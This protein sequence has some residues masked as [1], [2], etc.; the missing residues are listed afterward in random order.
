MSP[1][2][3]PRRK[4][5]SNQSTPISQT[6]ATRSRASI[7]AGFSNLFRRATGRRSPIVTDEPPAT[8]DTSKRGVIPRLLPRKAS[9]AGGNKRIVTDPVTHLRGTSSASSTCLHSPSQTP[10]RNAMPSINIPSSV[11]EIFDDENIHTS[12]DISAAI[13]ATEQE[14][15]RLLHDFNQLETTMAYRVHLQTARRLPPTIPPPSPDRKSHRR[16]PAPLDLSDGASVDSR[17]SD[18]TSLSQSKSVSSLRSKLY[19]PS[20]LSPRFFP[21]IHSTHS[22]SSF[23]SQVPSQGRAVSASASRS[24]LVDH[25]EG[26]AVGHGLVEGVDSHIEVLEVQQRRKEVMARCETRVE[27]LR[28]RLKGAELHEKL[29][30]K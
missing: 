4:H 25:E 23:S 17:S 14:A 3:V 11:S 12:E 10:T 7:A 1:L 16:I 29:L 18:R 6:P 9:S 30:K 22:A 15:A 24:M 20:P 19:P 28:A 26:D 2:P 21:P 13:L 8:N 5:P 27:Y